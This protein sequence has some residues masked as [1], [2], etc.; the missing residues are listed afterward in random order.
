MPTVIGTQ[1][2]FLKEL[3]N[4]TTKIEFI[5]KLIMMSF[6]SRNLIKFIWVMFRLCFAETVQ[7]PNS[8]YFR[9]FGVLKP[10]IFKIGY[11]KSYYRWQPY[12]LMRL[13]S[14]AT[15]YDYMVLMKFHRY[16]TPPSQ[17]ARATYLCIH[18]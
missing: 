17:L 11:S 15:P 12:H 8:R 7:E 18:E 2:L 5:F 16:E 4:V 6:D 3:A 13:V 14:F 9:H 1:P 10:T